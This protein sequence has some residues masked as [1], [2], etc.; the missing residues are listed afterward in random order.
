MPNLRAGFTI[1]DCL[2][3]SPALF[4][5]ELL[6]GRVVPVPFDESTVVEGTV[7][8]TTASS[9]D[10]EVRDTLAAGLK[11]KNSSQNQQTRKRKVLDCKITS[12]LPVA[13]S[14]GG[15][16][17]LPRHGS[18]TL[19]MPS[20]GIGTRSRAELPIT[21]LPSRLLICTTKAIHQ[22]CLYEIPY[23]HT[24]IWL[25]DRKGWKNKRANK[26]LAEKDYS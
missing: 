18:S 4:I 7:C 3:A 23:E 1:R 2:P 19:W 8:P 20:L 26:C 21:T 22:Y 5:L 24:E 25:I 14:L 6:A 11:K 9:P 16:A 17:M 13:S 15:V 10:A 12:Y